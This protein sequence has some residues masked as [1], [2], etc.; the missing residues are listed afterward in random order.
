[1]PR[2]LPDAST[3]HDQRILT[4]AA[5][6]REQLSTSGIEV[7][8]IAK[9]VNLSTSYL[10]HLFKEHMGVTPRRYHKLQ[11]LYRAHSLLQETFLSV[12]QVMAEVGWTDES[13]FCRDYKRVYGECPSKMK[14]SCVKRS[15]VQECTT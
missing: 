2:E 15:S 10:C 6:I 8:Q 11:R 5:W 12:K 13:H 3:V 14:W 9:A 1:M 4:A 7:D